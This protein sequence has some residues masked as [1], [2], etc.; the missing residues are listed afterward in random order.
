MYID[1]GKIFLPAHIQKFHVR[2]PAVMRWKGG[3][4]NLYQHAGYRL[5]H[6]YGT[7]RIFQFE[8]EPAD[9]VSGLIDDNT[10][11]LV[12]MLL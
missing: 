3:I 4:E 1:H 5:V 12:I 10:C 9:P 11:S 8:G 2:W 7:R 6:I